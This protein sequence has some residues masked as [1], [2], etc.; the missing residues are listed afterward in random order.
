MVVEE[1][2]G[3]TEKNQTAKESKHQTKEFRSYYTGNRK[4]EAFKQEK[5]NQYT[6]AVDRMDWRD[7]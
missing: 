7:Y 5:I 2:S 1:K 4:T 6:K 3:K